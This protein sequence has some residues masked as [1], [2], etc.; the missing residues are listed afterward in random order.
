[1]RMLFCFISILF[2]LI[3]NAQFTN[4]P[5]FDEKNLKFGYF[6]GTNTYD[7]KIL[8]KENPRYPITV[9]RGTGLNIGLIGELKINKNLNLSFEPGLYSNNTKI[10]FNERLFFT[11][12]NDTLWNVKSNNIHLPILLKYNSKRLGNFKPYLQAG[13]S[14]S[15]NLG[16]I[17]GSF[18][19]YLIENLNF[20]DV[21]F[22]YELGFGIDFYLRYFKFS[23]SIRGVF[24]I[25][26]ELPENIP[27]N[28]WTG[29]IEK[30]FT[31]AIFINLSFY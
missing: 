20:D 1:M 3:S 27:K 21:G 4:L 26:N 8:Y 18:E 15:L 10:I 16:K 31:R 5:N 29:N 12:F 9:E 22:F 30:M 11:S 2:F 17:E 23:P 7:Y 13:V 19:N 6:I 25:K 28:P 24:S 14:T